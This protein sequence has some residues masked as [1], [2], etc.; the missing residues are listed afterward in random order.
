MLN[1]MAGDAIPIY[2]RSK[3]I[4]MYK[5]ILLAGALCAF[6]LAAVR[7]TNA[8]TIDV[9]SNLG[10]HNTGESTTINGTVQDTNYTYGY[11]AGDTVQGGSAPASLN[12]FAMQGNPYI[13]NAGQFPISTSN[14]YK[15]STNGSSNWVSPQSGYG[16]N[17]SDLAGYYAYVTTFTLPN[18]APAGLTFSFSGNWATDNLGEGI[19]LNGNPISNTGMGTGNLNSANFQQLHSFSFS[20]PLNYGQNTLAFI[21]YNTPFDGANPSGLRVANLDVTTTQPVPEPGM[22]QFLATMLCS[23]GVFAFRRR[24]A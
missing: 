1:S 17:N 22:L 3:E 2:K 24:R 8:A 19:W 7:P 6:A 18:A 23:G 5:K 20:T 14:W 10:L 15:D 21:V 16:S 12:D 9:T 4:E 11:T 13:T